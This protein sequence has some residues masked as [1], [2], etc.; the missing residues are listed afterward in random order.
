MTTRY[1]IVGAGAVGGTVGGLLT[2][3]GVPTVLVARGEHARVLRESGLRLRTPDEDVRL[4]VT[5]ATSADEVTLTPDDV[6]VFTT[7]TQQLDAALA[8]WVDAPVSGGGT[9]GERLPAI[10]ATNGVVSEEKA[11]Q[12]FRRVYGATVYTPASHLD[13]GEVVAQSAPVSA[14]WHVGRWPDRTQTP[15]DR[16]L[17]EKLRAEWEPAGLLI[18]VTDE[19]AAWKYEKLLANLANAV[20]ALADPGEDYSEIVAAARAEGREILDHAGVSVASEDEVAAWLDKGLEAR[21]VPGVEAGRGF[22]TWQSLA[23]GTGNIETDFLNGEIV[24]LAHSAGGTAPV[25]AALAR[26][27]R[28]AARSGAGAGGFSAVDLA[29]AVGL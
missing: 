22:S 24:R 11:L 15:E 17:L 25:N 10:T 28:A 13:P 27:A 19:P 29:V 3:A 26:L 6:L 23:R 4:P 8:D 9:A 21:P 16:E 18:N 2:R 20:N 14:I 5:V 12:H 7:K 1:I